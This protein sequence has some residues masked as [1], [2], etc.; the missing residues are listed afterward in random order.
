MESS[1]NQPFIFL[2]PNR[3]GGKRILQK[4]KESTEAAGE[5]ST[6]KFKTVTKADELPSL[7]GKVREYVIEQAAI[8]QPDNIH[9]CSG[10]PEDQAALLKIMEESGMVKPLRKYPNCWLTRTDPADVARVESKTVICT[11]DKHEA[12][13]E[14]SAGGKG[15][16]GNW[17]SLEDFKKGAHARFT[18]A[19]HGRT[20]YIVPFNMGPVG[21]PLAKTGIEL[22]DSPYV[23]ASMAVMT[24]MGSE[25]LEALHGSDQF[26][27]CVHSVGCPLPIS[28]PLVQH[29]PCNPDLVQIA[30]LPH[31]NMIMSFGS[32]Y[33]GNSLLGKKCLALRL[34][35]RLAYAENWLAEH[36][37]IVGI[38]PP[39]GRKRYIVAAFP[40]QC[41]KTNMAMMLPTIPG[42]KIECVGDDIAWM[43]FDKNGQLRA[44]N[45]EAGLFGVAPGTSDATNPMAMK[46][47]T[48]N[49]LFTNV[50]ETA[51]GDFY[52]EGLEDNYDPN[53]PVTD[54]KGQP[55]QPGCGR[56]ASH[57]NARFCAP[58][59]Q[60]PSIDPKA[61]DP[62][63]V[64]I[65]AII[66]GG[67]RPEG[68][69][70]VTESLSW[71]HG[72]FFGACVRS[73]T[74]AAA[75]FKGK[76]IMHDPFAMRPFFGYN[77]GNYVQHWLDMPKQNP[78]AKLPRIYQANW[79]RRGAAG[80]FLWPGFGE[81]CRVLEWILRRLDGDEKAGVSTPV[82][83]LPSKDSFNL[84]G[85]DKEVDWEQ[86]FSVPRDFWMQEAE[87][88]KHFFDE[89]VGT[90][91][92]P[93]MYEEL[94]ALKARL[95]HTK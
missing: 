21:S 50:A 25:V 11:P 86:L 8:M 82:G 88:M 32:G 19:M 77:F 43:K 84:E 34:G 47:I 63:G 58:V 81:N 6:Y 22:T 83:V 72:V 9:L 5:M 95:N 44:I 87:Q 70:L 93:A 26:V 89:Q 35:S 75:E 20:M 40:S 65:D 53:D 61:H 16:L 62:E 31:E 55:W 71:Q 41:G 29:W 56:P 94:E 3:L 69:P 2:I 67:R 90:D 37:L 60:I 23:A 27:K 36:M 4:R 51:S 10:T 85:L 45:P 48:R 91:M 92:P 76:A 38:T 30:H 52:W 74:T 59:D 15:M 13:P 18:G 39:S 42:F 14:P 66:F 17:I 7:E 73:E 28:K 33:G 64:P 54:W 80:E 46:T 57:P 24:R 79:F 12:I 68:V 49:T 78:G 1:R